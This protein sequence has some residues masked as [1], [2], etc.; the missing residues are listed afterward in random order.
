[1]ESLKDQPSAHECLTSLRKSY[2]KNSMSNFHNQCLPEL[3]GRY[4]KLAVGRHSKLAVGRHSK[5]AVGR[6][7]K[8]AVGRHSKLAACR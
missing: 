4:S 3:L 6:Y 5:L 7:S 2:S 8:L 1:M